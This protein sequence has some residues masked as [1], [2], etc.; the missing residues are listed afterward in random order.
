MRTGSDTTH[1][2]PAHEDSAHE[3]PA[4]RL[5]GPDDPEPVFVER[6][7]GES[8]FF[9]TC[10]HAGRDVPL[11]LGTLG[12]HPAEFD[13]HIA[14]DIGAEQTSRRLSDA[15]DAAIVGQYVSRLV[16]D[17]NRPH[18]AASSIP[19]ISE[20]TEIPGNLALDEEAREARRRE[21]F[22]PYHDRLAQE[23]DARDAEE[24]RTVLIAMHSFTPVY[25]G[26]AR[27]WQIGTL[28][29]HDGRLA[30]AL[31]DALMREGGLTVGDN[32]PYSVSSETDYTIP[33]HAEG[34]GLLHVGIE[35]RQDLVSDETGQARWADIL[36]RRLPEALAAIDRE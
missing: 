22:R 2:N 1:E 18:G 13:R 24:R 26:V 4:G 33:V 35:I 9:I 10:D 29:G 8:P 15:L 30:A 11:A 16:I 3:D 23:L 7:E 20:A 31:R 21:I 28:Y 25:L 34:R 17:C 32:E 6:L 14:Y 36:A 27:P 19:T 12:L 5:L